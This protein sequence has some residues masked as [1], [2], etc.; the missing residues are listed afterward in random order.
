MRNKHAAAV[1][2]IV[3]FDDDFCCIKSA[4]MTS[5]GNNVIAVPAS[6]DHLLSSLGL[7]LPCWIAVSEDFYSEA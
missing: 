5:N 7:P 4:V 1:L 6:M 2:S 3:I